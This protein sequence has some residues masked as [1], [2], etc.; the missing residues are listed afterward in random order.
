[1]PVSETVTKPP[2][3]LTNCVKIEMD[4]EARP[5]DEVIGAASFI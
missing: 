1:M 2:I 5:I 3:R 4:E